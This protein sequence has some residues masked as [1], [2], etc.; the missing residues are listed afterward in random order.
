MWL[1]VQEIGV[2]YSVGQRLWTTGNRQ[3]AWSCYERALFIG[4]RKLPADHSMIA[5]GLEWD[6]KEAHSA[7]YDTLKTA[8]LFCRIVNSWNFP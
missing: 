6:N 7:L 4:C 3:S 8:E 1:A 5:A 2:L